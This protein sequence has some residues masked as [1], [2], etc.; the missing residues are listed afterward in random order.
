ML[1]PEGGCSGR[2][3]YFVKG[4]EPKIAVSL[5]QPVLIQKDTNQPVQPGDLKENLEW[6][7]HAMNRDPL[8]TIFCFDCP[9]NVDNT[10]QPWPTTNIYVPN[11]RDPFLVPGKPE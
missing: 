2:Y 8:G 6:Q 4:T 11:N 5:R 10:D 3:E 7:D 1:P 9:A